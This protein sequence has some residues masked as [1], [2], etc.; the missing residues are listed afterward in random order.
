MN[1][2]RNLFMVC[3]GGVLLVG[4]A[5]PPDPPVED[6]LGSALVGVGQQPVA[7][8]NSP[9]A[10]KPDKPKKPTPEELEAIEDAKMERRILAMAHYAA[11]VAHRERGEGREATEEFYKAALADPTNEKIVME[12]VQILLRSRQR[13]KLFQLLIKA[14]EDPDAPANIHALLAANY[15]ERKKPDLAKAAAENAIRK[16]PK[17]IV[18]YKSLIQVYR[19]EVGKGAK[20][21]AQIRKVLDRAME[22]K[23]VSTPYQVDW[24][25]C[26]LVI[27][28]WAKKLRTN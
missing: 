10:A 21:T 13:E 4:C 15:L 9:A 28:S 27:L 20:R 25:S 2:F 23:E 16:G 6:T 11:G 12:V 5:L 1:M 17:L 18:G 26:S 22:Q 8:L 24:R 7:N 14:T 19:Q 3:T